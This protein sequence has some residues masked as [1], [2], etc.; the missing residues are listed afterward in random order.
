MADLAVVRLGAVLDKTAEAIL[1]PEK[2][3]F[4]FINL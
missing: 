4:K 1:E 3:M 2:I